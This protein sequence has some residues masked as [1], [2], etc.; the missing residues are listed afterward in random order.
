MLLLQSS[1][2]KS[3]EVRTPTS[4]PDDLRSLFDLSSE[5]CCKYNQRRDAVFWNSKQAWNSKLRADGLPSDAKERI[6][7]TPFSPCLEAA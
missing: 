3:G 4:Y 5:T 1:V 2:E 7:L 6:C